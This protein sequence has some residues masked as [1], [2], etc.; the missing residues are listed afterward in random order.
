M[1]NYFSFLLLPLFILPMSMSL[2]GCKKEKRV[3]IL[4]VSPEAVT[5][6]NEAGSES[7]SV[8]AG[9]AQWTVT[10]KEN[11]DWCTVK[12]DGS[13]AI[14]SV[15]E[16]PSPEIR[17]AVLTISTDKLQKEVS[18]SQTGSEPALELSLD[19]IEMEA[20]GG[21][22]DVDITTNLNSV[23]ATSNT[24]WCEVS[25]NKNKLTVKV[26]ANESIEDRSASVEVKADNLSK[27]V[28]V[29]QKGCEPSLSLDKNELSA[30]AEGGSFEVKVSTNISTLTAQSSEVWC[31]AELNGTVLSI[32]VE[33]NSGDVRSAEVTVSGSGLEATVAVSQES[34]SD[35]LRIDLPVDF[36]DNNVINVVDGG[37]KIAEIC[38]EYIASENLI[39]DVIYPVKDGKADLTA[40]I[41]LAN[42]GSVSWNTSDNSCTYSAGSKTLSSV[43]IEDGTIMT[44]YDGTGKAA[45][46]EPDII[47]D[48]RGAT[49]ETYKTVKIGT[50]YWMAENLRAEKYADGKDISTNWTD[51]TEGAYI[52]LYESPQDNKALLG[53]LY[54]G[55]AVNNPSGLAPKGWKVPSNDDWTKLIGYIGKTDTGAK[56]KSKQ[57]WNTNPGT[58]ET[59]FDARPGQSYSTATDFID[60]NMETWFWSTNTVKDILGGEMSQYYLRL[61][62]SNNKATF[63]TDSMFG[64]FHS[65]KF[66]HSV[67]CL[68]E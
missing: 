15:T 62:D 67:R 40:G 66:G 33:A 55:F 6:G 16:N 51:N 29:S 30:G 58:N 57:Y 56:M 49:S 38:R 44:E 23:I 17:R 64:T 18:V 50:Q 13:T 37:T 46:L 20:E 45:T 41:D 2:Y 19:K 21:T 59:G 26:A 7:I 10:V 61:V 39:A 68:K 11:P 48:V 22:A 4:E 3:D 63:N 35:A 43:W 34:A 60:A 47:V 8:E 65:Q 53:A 28:A 5:F 1:R 52:Y 31:K 25:L 36:T 24:E 32:E 9:N 12:Q 14:V 42:G 27:T 54:S